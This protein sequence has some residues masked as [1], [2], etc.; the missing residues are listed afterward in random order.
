MIPFDEGI[1]RIGVLKEQETL[2]A[3]AKRVEAALNTR[4]QASGNPEWMISR[5]AIM[6]GSGAACYQ[7]RY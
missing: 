5:V 6:G 7:H 2:S 4:G 3:F 1:G